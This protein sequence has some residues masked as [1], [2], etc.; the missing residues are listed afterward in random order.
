MTTAKDKREAIRGAKRDRLT[1]RLE[2]RVVEQAARF[3]ARH[4]E[5]P[6]ARRPRQL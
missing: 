2:K 1:E 3:R 4:A 5:Q 6:T